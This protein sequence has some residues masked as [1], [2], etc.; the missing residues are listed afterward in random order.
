MSVPDFTVVIRNKHGTRRV[1]Y[2]EYR[3]AEA[4]ARA[5]VARGVE[6]EIWRFDPHAEPIGSSYDGAWDRSFKIWPRSGKER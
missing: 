5:E 6:V 2:L 1:C 4:R 3:F